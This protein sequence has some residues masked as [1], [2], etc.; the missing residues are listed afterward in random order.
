MGEISGLFHG[1]FVCLFFTVMLKAFCSNVLNTLVQ[2]NTKVS[3]KRTPK[4][5]LSVLYHSIMQL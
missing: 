3:G 1:L 5:T 2:G 4:S